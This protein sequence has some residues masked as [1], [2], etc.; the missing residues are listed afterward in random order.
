MGGEPK[1]AL[2]RVSFPLQQMELSVLRELIQGFRDLAVPE[3]RNK[4]DPLG[5]FNFQHITYLGAFSRFPSE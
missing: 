2:N 4:S 1:I 5:H 3:N